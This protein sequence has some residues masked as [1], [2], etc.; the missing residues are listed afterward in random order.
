MLQ[1]YGNTVPMD[2]VPTVKGERHGCRVPVPELQSTIPTALSVFNAIKLGGQSVG[3]TVVDVVKLERFTD[4]QIANAKANKAY[5]DQLA[6]NSAVAY[7]QGQGSGRM[8]MISEPV[9]AAIIYGNPLPEEATMLSL[10]AGSDYA[11]SL[12]SAP[13]TICLAGHEETGLAIASMFE[14][15]GKIAIAVLLVGGAAYYLTQKK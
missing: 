5:G 9:L 7:M 3:D 10:P 8:V 12:A 6:A 15:P 11:K 1:A 13:G 2:T 14:S 4:E